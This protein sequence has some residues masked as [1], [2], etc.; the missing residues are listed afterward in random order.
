MAIIVGIQFQKNGKVYNF[1]VN[2]L[3]VKQDDYVIAETA[4]GIDLGQVVVGCRNMEKTDP[5]IPLK[6]LIRIATEKDLQTSAE[7]RE[8]EA[9]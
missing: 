7:N 6:K 3:D 8:K 1:D 5:A 9:E 4:H 2:N